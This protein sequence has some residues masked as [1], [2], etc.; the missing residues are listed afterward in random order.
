M[1]ESVFHVHDLEQ[2]KNNGMGYKT[3]PQKTEKK[4]DDTSD[5]G[6]VGTKKGHMLPAKPHAIL[7]PSLLSYLTPGMSNKGASQKKNTGF[8]G[9]FSH[10]G[11][12]VLLNPKTFVI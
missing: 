4:P 6:L 3:G 2:D 10:T 12:G 8:F 7:L 1:C 9:S 11:G 5:S